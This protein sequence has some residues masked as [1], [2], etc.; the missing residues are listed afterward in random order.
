[1]TCQ[2]CADTAEAKRRAAIR[3]EFMQMDHYGK[4]LAIP[5]SGKDCIYR[6]SLDRDGDPVRWRALS[7][8]ETKAVRDARHEPPPVKR[9][10]KITK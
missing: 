5:T 10:R 1:M 2:F 7:P 3:Q 6:F 8:E 9:K 4:D